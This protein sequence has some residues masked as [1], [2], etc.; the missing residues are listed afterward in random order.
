MRLLVS[1]NRVARFSRRSQ[2]SMAPELKPLLVKIFCPSLTTRSGLRGGFGET[3][4][5]GRRILT[6][7]E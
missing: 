5:T 4:F 1:D 3:S 6:V 7:Q 2:P